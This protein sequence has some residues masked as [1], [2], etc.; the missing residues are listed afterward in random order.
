MVR[1]FHEDFL[2]LI[3]DYISTFIMDEP[4]MG[5]RI[6]TNGCRIQMAAETDGGEIPLSPLRKAGRE[7]AVVIQMDIRKA[8]RPQL[9]LQ[10]EGEIPLP[11]ARGDSLSPIADTFRGDGLITEETIEKR[12]TVW[13]HDCLL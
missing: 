2:F 5:R 4:G 10:K 8:Q 7:T 11:P 1:R 13:S 12:L 9:F 6:S 3:Q